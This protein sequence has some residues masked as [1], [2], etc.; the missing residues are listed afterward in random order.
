MTIRI[1]LVNDHGPVLFLDGARNQT[2][3]STAFMESQP[4]LGGPEPVRVSDRLQIADDDTGDQYLIMSIVRITD[5]M[6][7]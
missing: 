6:H 1:Q 3:Y 7:C 2:D 4:Y 5:G